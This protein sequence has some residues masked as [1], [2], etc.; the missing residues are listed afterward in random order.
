MTK[1]E[2]EERKRK[3]L[4][5]LVLPILRELSQ[6]RHSYGSMT[7]REDSVFKDTEKEVQHT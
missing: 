7:T 6:D 4:E 2:R 5:E 1:E 3:L